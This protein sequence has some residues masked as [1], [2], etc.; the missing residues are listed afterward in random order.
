MSFESAASIPS[1]SLLLL[2]NLDR[3]DPSKNRTV[4]FK[5]LT[6]PN[7]NLLCST[8]AS[9]DSSFGIRSCGGKSIDEVLS[10]TKA[11]PNKTMYNRPDNHC[12]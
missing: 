9:S 11:R 5:V 4:K 7:D 8:E 3:Y 1:I 2:I 12:F 10:D 6:R